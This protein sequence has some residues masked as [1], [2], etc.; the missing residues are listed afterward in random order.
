MI[1]TAALL[2]SGALL[3]R[4]SRPGQAG[5]AFPGWG[6]ISVALAGIASIVVVALPIASTSA[7]R[8]SQGS[9][10]AGDLSQALSEAQSASDIEPYAATP[11]LQAA[12][13]FERLGNLAAAA[14]E[15]RAATTRGSDD[16]RNWTTLSRIEAK[17][18]NAAASVA[19]YRRARA[20]NPRSLLFAR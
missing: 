15:A 3:T 4:R 10:A 5:A 17:R 13:L 9:A 1:P 16:W 14:R 2:L 11:R 6:R 8:Q 19:A 12:L 20:L 18:G 7:V